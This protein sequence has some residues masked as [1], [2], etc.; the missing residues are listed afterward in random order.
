MTGC[1]R[2][3][4][5]LIAGWMVVVVS[6]TVATLFREV[7]AG[8]PL[9]AFFAFGPGVDLKVLGIAIDTPARYAVVVTYACVNACVRATHA[10]VLVPWLVHRVQHDGNGNGDG[11]GNG[12]ARGAAVMAYQAYQAVLISTAYHWV[13]WATSLVFL[14]SQLDLLLIE[15]TADMLAAAA[16]TAGYLRSQHHHRHQHEREHLIVKR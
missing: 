2:V 3:C 5:G 16:T 15:M 1:V 7:T 8:Q 6:A 10:N 12:N 14:L 9:P 4:L 11:D 13:D